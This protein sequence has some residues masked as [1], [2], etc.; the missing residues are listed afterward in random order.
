MTAETVL[1]LLFSGIMLGFLVVDL[2]YLSRLPHRV[3]T[4]E[5][6]LQSLF[7]VTISLAYAGVVGGLLGH[8]AAVEFTSAYITEKMLSVDNLFVILLIFN[9]FKIREEH[10]HRVLYWGIMGAVFFRGLFIGGGS[11]IIEHFHWVLYIFGF[12]LLWSAWK[13]IKGGGDEDQ[14]LEQYRVFK[15]AK[16]WLPIDFE[17][18]ESGGFWYKKDGKFTFTLLF[19]VLLMVETTDVLFAFD[20]IPAVFSITQNPLLVFTSNIFAVM[21]L[22]ALFF[23]VEGLM[24]KLCYLQQGLS[25][26][27]AFIGVK[28][29]LGIWHVHID[30]LISFGVIVGVLGLSCI[31][32]WKFPKSV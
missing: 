7:W 8:E 20:S 27:L 17:N 3:T 9:F 32:S 6:T 13:L 29:L 18:R 28:M 30:S 12:I 25:V 5:A 22:R 4:K 21:G 24:A 31:L 2:G 16:R 10:Y 19:L 15:W 1:W 26:I 23:L 14:D 11:V